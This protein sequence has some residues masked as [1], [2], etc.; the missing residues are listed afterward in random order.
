M[1]NVPF[2]D[3]FLRSIAPPPTGQI[4]YWDASFSGGCFGC[5]V[6]QGGAKTFVLKKDNRRQSLGRFPHISLARAREAA[7]V[8]L[9]ERTLGRVRPHAVPYTIAVERFIEDKRRNRR[10]KTCVE[11]E[12]LLRRLKFPS[13]LCE[14]THH[15]AQRQLGRVTAPSEYNHALVVAKV[16]FNWCRKRHLIEHNPLD[17]LSQNSTKTRDRVLTTCEIKRV[18]ETAHDLGKFGIIVRLLIL[19]GQ[20]RGEVAALRPA[21]FKDRICT[22]PESVTKNKREHSFP[23]GDLS[24]SVLPPL[25][26]LQP[27]GLLFPARGKPEHPFNGWSKSKRQLDAQSRVQQWTLHDLRRTFRTIHAKIGTPPHIA[28]RL[29][30]HVAGVASDVQQIYD[31]HRYLDE[32]RDAVQRYEAHLVEILT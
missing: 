25:N 9:A 16:F 31:R 30:N 5:R 32:M 8:L 19:T 22:L 24:A 1:P 28:E 27:D 18:W 21:F 10:P 6:S 12:R 17:G 26:N 14:I 4:D 11:Y 15:E 23:I 13:A 20:R 29:I 3:A 2:S 7:R